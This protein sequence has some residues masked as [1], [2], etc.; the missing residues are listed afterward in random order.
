MLKI[1]NVEIAA[2]PKPGD[3]KVTI[4]D[5]DDG[6]STVRTSDGT[7]HRDR[8]AV[9]RQVEMSFAPLPDNKI[10]AIL[11]A[12]SA[13]FFDFYYPDPMVG[14]YVTKRMY[15]GNR[16]AA[17]PIER[18]GVLWWDGLQITLTEQ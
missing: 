12:M 11:Q 7:L 6:E 5:L 1:N 4:L 9:K 10:S 18:N 17:V 2:Y 13:P 8:I 14:G 3:F 15:V 16:P